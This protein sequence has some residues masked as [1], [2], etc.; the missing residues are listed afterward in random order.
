MTQE[1]VGRM[2]INIGNAM[3]K[4]GKNAKTSRQLD[5]NFYHQAD[6]VYQGLYDS[7]PPNANYIK[8]RKVDDMDAEVLEVEK[9][10]PKEKNKRK[11][12]PVAT[13][14]K[15]D[16]GKDT[17]FVHPVVVTGK[18]DRFYESPDDSDDSNS[19]DDDVSNDD[20]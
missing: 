4:K 19:Y 17:A 12:T 5:V 11:R 14:V 18:G 9:Y 1:D 13:E 7:V 8:N 16:P 15:G 6:D 20:V 10:I 2:L 3:T